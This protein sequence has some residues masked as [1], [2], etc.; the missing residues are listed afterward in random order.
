MANVCSKLLGIIIYF[1]T[2]VMGRLGFSE[3]I[4]IF[5]VLSI[6]IFFP[7]RFLW[8]IR[9][10]I[11]LCGEHNRLIKPNKVWLSLV[12]LFGLFWQ[13]VMIN[14]VGMTL[15]AEFNER[16]IKCQENKPGY[17]EGIL[18]STLMICGIIPGIGF[19]FVL[20]GVVC[21]IVNWR[22]MNSYSRLLMNHIQ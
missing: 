14:K 12:P 7:L 1:N 21:W 17:S 2:I 4:L 15:R 16:G 8:K 11:S 22:K 3:F 13:F 18:Y 19:L 9:Q 6:I 20:V 5:F 10:M